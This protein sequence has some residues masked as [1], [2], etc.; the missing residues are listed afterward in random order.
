MEFPLDRVILSSTKKG[1]VYLFI[2]H[3]TPARIFILCTAIKLIQLIKREHI[4]VT[5]Q[6]NLNYTHYDVILMKSLLG[7]R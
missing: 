5:F 1:K 3:I 7:N 4:T 6:V 2:K